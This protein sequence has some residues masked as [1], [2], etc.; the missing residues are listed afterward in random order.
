MNDSL[1]SITPE[2]RES[3]VIRQAV[4]VDQLEIF[5]LGLEKVLGELDI[6]VSHQAMRAGDGL[7]SAQARGVGLVIVGKHADLKIKEPLR[8]AKRKNP[9][10]KVMML[11][12]QAQLPDVALLVGLGVD[13]LLLRSAKSAEVLD[14]IHRLGQGE[15]VVASALA[16][17]T[18]GRVGPVAMS[19][20]QAGERSGLSP[21]ELEVLGELATG[22]SYKEIADA[23]IVTQATV[24]TH[25]VHIYAKLEVK[26]R[27]EA[28]TRA[29][30]LGLLG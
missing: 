9:E 10:L 13:A 20:G 22:A 29:L 27:N 6:L 1:T 3:F 7:R 8:V 4:V 17:G 21:K 30:A 5:R 26:N 25:L 23:L 28:V 19:E 12:D 14:A 16:V 15:R 24:K 2:N 18:V 11:L